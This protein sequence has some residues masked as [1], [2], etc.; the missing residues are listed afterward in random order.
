MTFSILK[1]FTV[2]IQ[3]YQQDTIY[4]F[5]SLILLFGLF[6]LSLALDIGDEMIIT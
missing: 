5:P 4:A 6:A 2:G 3:H 1:S